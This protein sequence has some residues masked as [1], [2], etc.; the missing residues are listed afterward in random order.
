MKVVLWLLG[1]IL[2]LQSCT[3][4]YSDTELAGIAAVHQLYQGNITYSKHFGDDGDYFLVKLTDTEIPL[5]LDYTLEI[6]G[7][8]IGL[9][10]L[11]HFTEEERNQY[12]WIK[13]EVVTSKGPQNRTVSM[14]IL[15]KIWDKRNQSKKD[16]ELLTDGHY[17][18]Y[19][20]QLKTHQ[21]QQFV[22]EQFDS[23]VG[24][25]FVETGALAAPIELGVDTIGYKGKIIGTY[26]YGFKSATDGTIRLA[27]RATY[28]LTETD[29]II[30][31]SL[32]SLLQ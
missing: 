24:A 14:G 4:E 25:I 13:V 29:S 8:N 23:L 9:M 1:A 2:L 7:H 15:Q 20:Y 11:E 10:M 3:A 31:F 5:E 21:Q 17:Q 12:Y 6:A 26:Y 32:Q 27:Y 22:P 18:D 30:D 19:Y 28:A 16:L